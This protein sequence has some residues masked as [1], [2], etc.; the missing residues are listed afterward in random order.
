MS[1]RVTS[2]ALNELTETIQ[3]LE[4]LT[5]KQNFTK[6]DEHRHAFLL[7]KVSLLKQ[8]VSGR[9]IAEARMDSLRAELGIPKYQ[10]RKLRIT[11]PIAVAEWRSMVEDAKEFQRMVARGEVRANEA[12]TQSITAPSGSV[13]GFLVP[14]GYDDR[15]DVL[16]SKYNLD[17]IVM[18]PYC[19]EFDTGKG[20]PMTTPVVDDF[21]LVGSPASV[22]MSG[23]VPEST[24]G[25]EQ[26]M[27]VGRVAWPEV[28]TWRTG[29][30]AVSWEL[31]Q[32]AQYGIESVAGLIEAV[33]AKRHA[34]GLG[35]A[36]IT[37]A[38]VTSGLIN[39]LPSGT[40]ITSAA[41]TL[42]LPDFTGLYAELPVWYRKNAVWFM[43]D[44]TRLA[45]YNLLQTSGRVATE[46]P[47]QFMGLPI[48]VCNSMTPQAAG[49]KSVVVIADVTYLQKRKA[50][51][52]V[53][54]YLEAVG[55][56]E[57]GM[58]GFQGFMRADF[59]PALLTSPLPPIASLN[60]HA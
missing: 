5:S 53:Q 52:Y 37:G 6:Q 18:P 48:G 2:I 47:T 10:M 1:I 34:I 4:T 24:Q 27:V 13:G 49:A 46:L 28:P 58:I 7:A 57:A 45:L 20:N 30:L 41:S 12:G 38:G 25:T 59:S 16:M 35:R 17:A 33:F 56:A 40:T 19:A 31:F 29:R 39:N 15:Q 14:F 21:A 54:R 50:G 32:D 11:N 60:Q 22:N 3:E 36:M 8:G 43:H 55:H 51:T 42:A 26:D 23:S 9:D 44:N